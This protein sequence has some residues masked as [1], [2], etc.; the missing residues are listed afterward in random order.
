MNRRHLLA[1]LG[2]RAL[3][4]A[5]P[6]WT[7]DRR[8]AQ[9][10]LPDGSLEI[11]WI[12]P[13]SFALI[14]RWLDSTPSPRLPYRQ[15]EFT[16]FEEGEGVE[17]RTRY[18]SV[19]VDK[20]SFLLTV[21][22][23]EG[24]LLLRETA[25]ARRS[26]DRVTLQFALQ[27]DEQIYGLGP[28]SEPELNAR[29]RRLTTRHPLLISTAGYGMYH[30]HRGEVDF[31]LTARHIV[32]IRG[33]DKVEYAFYFGP[34][35]KSVLEEHALVRPP[36]YDGMPDFGIRRPGE[37]PREAFLL[38]GPAK[39]SWDSLNETVRTLIHASFSGIHTPAFDLSAY[40]FSEPALLD[41]ARQLA[42]VIPFVV[43]SGTHE[44]VAAMRSRLA[45]YFAT[46]LQEAHDLGLP[47]VHPLPLQFATD[48]QT[49]RRLDA[50]LLGDELLVAPLLTA[51]ERRSV[52]LPMGIWTDLHT[53]QEHRGRQTVEVAS[54]PQGPPLL[55]RNGSIVPF[56]RSD[57][58]I[59]LHYF[60]N[61]GAEFFLFETEVGES[62]QFHA[63]PA[64]DY[65]RLEIESKVSR[66]YE[67]IIHHRGPARELRGPGKWHYDADRNNLH[68]VMDGPVGEDRIVNLRL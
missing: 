65:M 9:F 59:E 31:D 16:A 29:G 22:D 11:Q 2:T 26:R 46:Y 61:L 27:K 42:A 8:G 40:E 21:K 43:A 1:L 38:P 14:R 44:S 55:A 45:P 28:R 5:R 56:S 50:F 39:A 3:S 10:P 68:V 13:S 23:D 60:P 36:E 67:W 58:S 17:L 18:L 20:K 47:M 53:N 34:Y 24:R 57:G 12:S 66:T 33:A 6:S 35:P 64:G 25:P 15:V 54:P 19:Q 51:S 62:S 63:A 41:R 52:Y 7:W 37:L 4:G 32:S 30:L 49:T 48:P